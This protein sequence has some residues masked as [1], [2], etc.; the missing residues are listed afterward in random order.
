MV[1]FTLQALS[2]SM[3]TTWACG[4]KILVSDKEFD[5]QLDI[6]T[7]MKKRALK[8]YGLHVSNICWYRSTLFL[9]Y[10]TGGFPSINNPKDLDLSC[11]TDLDLWDC[12]GRENSIS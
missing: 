6:G 4:K 10:M 12:F 7:K 8:G 5:E 1:L 2:P 11:K 3:R 9:I